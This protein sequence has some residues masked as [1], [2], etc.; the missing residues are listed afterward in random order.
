MFIDSESRLPKAAFLATHRRLSL[1]AANLFGMNTCV[2]FRINTYKKTAGW[3]ALTAVLLLATASLGLASQAG[4]WSQNRFDFVGTRLT[5]QSPRKGDGLLA[6]A[7]SL[8]QQGKFNEADHAVRQYLQTH[9]DSADAHFLLGHILFREIQAEAGSESQA[10]DVKILAASESI[11]KFREEKAKASL[12]EFTDGAKYHD[13]DSSDLK[14]VALDYVLL[15][16]YPDA[17]KWLTKMLERTPSDSDGWYLLGRTKYNE[18]RFAEAISAFQGCLNLDSKNVKA[19]DNLGLSLAGLGRNVEA[20]DAYQ[21]AIAWQAELI[22]KNPG[23]Y[24]DLASL[25]IDQNRLQEAVNYLLQAIQIAPH[26]SRTHEL[27]AKAY[28]RL[29][30]F[31][32]AQTELEKAIALSPESP[33]LHCMLAPVYRKQ[34]LVE[35]AKGEFDRCAALTGNHSTPETPRP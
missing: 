31:Q 14:T 20:A 7:K 27:L 24:I 8:F 11:A 6:Y 22:A 5:T 32:K 29:E 33:N 25:L 21:Q 13:P 26:E 16:D 28:T 12:A 18:N 15:G 34:R 17:D 19:K 35:K 1:I 3:G 2:L 4:S 9:P 23:P 10:G 30:D